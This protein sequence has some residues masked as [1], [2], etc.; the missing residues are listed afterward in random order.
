MLTQ[1]VFLLGR[2]GSGAGNERP[3][4]RRLCGRSVVNNSARPV[5]A[6]LSRASATGNEFAA[7]TK[8]NRLMSKNE[9]PLNEKEPSI[10]ST[11]R[12]PQARAVSG[13][14]RGDDPSNAIGTIEIFG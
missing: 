11:R 14:L 6:T 2:K 13:L 12:A 1:A 9:C 10:E 3:G 8:S 7:S 5:S 4:R